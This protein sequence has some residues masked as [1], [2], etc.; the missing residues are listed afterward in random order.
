MRSGASRLSPRTPRAGRGWWPGAPT[1][2]GPLCYRTKRSALRAFLDA[3]AAAIEAWGG[4]LPGSRD[5]RHARKLGCDA[6]DSINEKYELRGRDRVCLLDDAIWHSLREGKAR[7]WCLDRIA[8]A[9]LNEIG[10]HIHGGKGP[11]LHLPGAAEEAIA[12]RR[13]EDYSRASEEEGIACGAGSRTGARACREV[14]GGRSFRL[15]AGRDNKSARRRLGQKL[16]V[17]YA[18]SRD[19]KGKFRRCRPREEAPF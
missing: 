7:H 16:A 9:M 12:A 19:S 14:A 18:C 10:D 17:D 8:L 6:F 5:R 4:F 1:G 11:R 13:W 15:R 3:N 2:G